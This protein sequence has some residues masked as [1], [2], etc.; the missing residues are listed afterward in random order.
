MF[1]LSTD[2]QV[3]A[4][5]VWDLVVAD[6]CD[7]YDIDKPCDALISEGTYGIENLPCKYAC[8]QQGTRC[9]Y[10]LLVKNRDMLRHAYPVYWK[11]TTFR[12]EIDAV[13]TWLHAWDPNG[14]WDLHDCLVTPWQTIR[15]LENIKAELEDDYQ[16]V[17]SWIDRAIDYLMV[18]AI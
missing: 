14:D 13:L 1:N 3:E 11:K 6:I 5:T 8:E 4:K 12:K 9:L 10:L 18:L 16:D 7:C 17:P 15:V 2:I